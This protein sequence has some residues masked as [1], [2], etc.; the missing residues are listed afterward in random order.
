MCLCNIYCII[1]IFILEIEGYW[2][3]RLAQLPG[4]APDTRVTYKVR[5]FLG[6]YHVVMSLQQ[7]LP[8]L[9]SRDV[10]RSVWTD[11]GCC[12]SKY[13]FQE[14]Y[15]EDLTSIFMA[16]SCSLKVGWVFK[17]FSLPLSIQTHFCLDDS[18]LLNSL[19]HHDSDSVSSFTD[20]SFVFNNRCIW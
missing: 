6:S 11:A 20:Q 18:W 1:V 19:L 13:H 10:S 4:G 17:I 8:L 9:G 3:N 2:N 5:W 14:S 12:F 16:D 7:V 15:F